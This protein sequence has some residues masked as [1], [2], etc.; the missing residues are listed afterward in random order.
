MCC[1]TLLQSMSSASTMGIVKCAVL[2]RRAAGATCIAV[3]FLACLKHTVAVPVDRVDEV[4]VLDLV[5]RWRSSRA[6]LP[7]ATGHIGS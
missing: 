2:D 5:A 3:A 6:V 1:V 4:Q 7:S